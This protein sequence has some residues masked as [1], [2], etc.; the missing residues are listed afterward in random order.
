MNK[1]LVEHGF[2]ERFSGKSLYKDLINQDVDKDINGVI[3][4]LKS[5]T[6]ANKDLSNLDKLY[7]MVRYNDVEAKYNSYKILQNQIKKLEKEK[8]QLDKVLSSDDYLLDLMIKRVLIYRRLNESDDDIYSINN[9]STYKSF[10]LAKNI[11]EG[12]PINEYLNTNKIILDLD[13]EGNEG[14]YYRIGDI[15]DLSNRLNET[16]KDISLSNFGYKE[17]AKHLLG[18]ENVLKDCENILYVSDKMQEILDDNKR[19]YK[20][21]KIISIVKDDKKIRNKEINNLIKLIE[22]DKLIQFGLD[23]KTDDSLIKRVYNGEVIST[24]VDDSKIS[25]STY[26]DKILIYGKKYSDAVKVLKLLKD[27]MNNP[28]VMRQIKLLTDELNS[29]R[30]QEELAIAK[31]KYLKEFNSRE[32][33]KKDNV[34]RDRIQ[35]IVEDYRKTYLDSI[36]DDSSINNM[37]QKYSNNLKMRQYMPKRDIKEIL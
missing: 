30:V 36:Y 29:P 31:S 8:A 5:S 25:I 17:K 15:S 35:S 18:K 19:T 24:V 12:I 11:Y 13:V 10:I 23:S 16:L 37:L 26:T 2:N 28:E 6:I 3:N 7:E 22:L 14:V 4:V 21:P 1:H 32:S 34:K 20:E 9:D 33:V 27:E